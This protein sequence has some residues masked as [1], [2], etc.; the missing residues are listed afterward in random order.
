MSLFFHLAQ[1]QLASV[2]TIFHACGVCDLNIFILHTQDGESPQK[3]KLLQDRIMGKRVMYPVFPPICYLI[4]VCEQI[5]KL[6]SSLR[7]A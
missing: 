7:I 3:D 4:E 2:K 1:L 6:K 5:T